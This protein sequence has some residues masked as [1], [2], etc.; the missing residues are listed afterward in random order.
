MGS[1]LMMRML[2]IVRERLGRGNASDH[3]NTEDEKTGEGTL[4]RTVRHDQHPIGL[5]GPAARWYWSRVNESRLTDSQRGYLPDRIHKNF[6]VY[7][8]QNFLTLAIG[9]PT[10]YII[11]AWSLNF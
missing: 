4:N 1:F 7:W 2:G 8:V 5:S 6:P 11:T 3:Q 9:T 10:L